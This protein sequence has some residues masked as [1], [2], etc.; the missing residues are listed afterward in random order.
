[1]ADHGR[2]DEGLAYPTFAIKRP[3]AHGAVEVNTTCASQTELHATILQCAG[4]P[5]P[6]GQT[7]IF[8]LDPE[9]DYE[10]R[11]LYYPTS[12]YNAGYLPDLTE[13]TISKGLVA[14]ETGRVFTREGV[15]E[16]N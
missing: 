8:D 10:R 12:L 4:L 16:A 9:A 5:V 14:K 11:Y 2:F 13:Y 6:E 3:G 15:V 1:M 7:S